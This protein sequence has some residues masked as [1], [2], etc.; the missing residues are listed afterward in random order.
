MTDGY[1]RESGLKAAEETGQLV[2]YRRT[3]HPLQIRVIALPTTLLH[4]LTSFYAA[5]STVLPSEEHS[6][7]QVDHL[8]E[9]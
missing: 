7:N 9:L 3:F 4:V 2:S 5:R 8:L 1:H 6:A